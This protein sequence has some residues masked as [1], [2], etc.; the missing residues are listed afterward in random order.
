MPKTLAHYLFLPLLTACL[1]AVA[2]SCRGDAEAASSAAR[3]L[4][5]ADRLHAVWPDSVKAYEDLLRRAIAEAA[6]CEDSETAVKASLRL[7]AQL[8]WTDEHEA[9]VLAERALA[10][11]QAG[12]S[13]TL[14][15]LPQIR[16]TI[17]GLREQM[18][19]EARARSLYERC[20]TDT[21]SRDVALSR[22]A[23]LYL[24]DGDAEGALRLARQRLTADADTADVEP[25][26]ILAN[27]YQQCDSLTAARGIYERLSR[28]PN[29]K[30]RYVALR[31]LSEIAILEQ[32]LQALPVILD[33][34]FANAEDVFFDAL[35]QKDNYFRGALEQ[36]RQ[37]E[38]LAYRERL[39]NWL[40]LGVLVVSA[41]VISFFVMLARH[42]HAIQLQRLQ[43]EQREH[44]LAE[45]R[46]QQREQKI[47]LLQ[48]YILEKSELLQRLRAEGD[49]KRQ[50]SPKEWT[51]M[52]QLLD[53]ITGGFV[54]R[55]RAQ[56]PT[57]SEEDI[58]L[59]ILTRMKLSNQVISDI[60]LITVSAVKHRKLKLKKSGFGETDPERSLDD[61][62]AHI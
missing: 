56:H 53:S 38:R 33:S 36:E 44:E 43:A 16:L 37:T 57:F 10:L 2:L 30:T 48:R 7:S 13:A 21:S 59:C 18:G 17:A 8:Q 34:A 1:V 31:H 25:Q 60:Y 41:V 26:L 40:L 39:L 42:R 51:D 4:A 14:S 49:H 11:A 50:L 35:Q 24:S 47:D 61:V 29:S 45:E 55:L 5:S 28:H 23:N 27:C 54:T 6:R 19:D 32:R 9:I 20:L 12:D 52:E 62:L 3:T 46:L 15:L 22:L 58:Q